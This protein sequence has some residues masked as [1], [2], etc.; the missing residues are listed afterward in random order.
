MLLK[1][2]YVICPPKVYS[3]YFVCFPSIKVETLELLSFRNIWK[4]LVN[5]RIP[6]LKI[7]RSNFKIID[8]NHTNRNVI[9]ETVYFRTNIHT[10]LCHVTKLE[11]NV[12]LKRVISPA[13]TD[14]PIVGRTG[15]E[16][17]SIPMFSLVSFSSWATRLSS[18]RNPY[19]PVHVLSIIYIPIYVICWTVIK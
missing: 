2:N 19:I 13:S 17:G 9:V 1:K 4:Q 5:M 8:R 7:L 6:A 12:T 18:F 14:D 15:V 16:P 3:A 11:K 10:H